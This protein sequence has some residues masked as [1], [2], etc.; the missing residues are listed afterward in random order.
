MSAYDIGAFSPSPSPSPAV[1]G[2]VNIRGS[3][4]VLNQSG[5]YWSIK[6]VKN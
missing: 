4:V 5:G 1:C 6:K 2:L 3:S